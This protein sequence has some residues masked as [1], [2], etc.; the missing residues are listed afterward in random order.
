MAAAKPE[1]DAVAAAGD[2]ANVGVWS[3]RDN[4]G[5][6]FIAKVNGS[7]VVVHSTGWDDQTKDVVAED[8][9]WETAEAQRV[10]VGKSPL[11]EMTRFSGGHGSDFDGNSILVQLSPNEYIYVGVTIDSFTPVSPIQTYVSP[12]GNSCVPY[13]YAIDT[14]GRVY[15]FAGNP[16][17]LEYMTGIPANEDPN[18]YYWG[19]KP[20]NIAGSV[21]LT[22]LVPR[23]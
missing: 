23:Q 5:T 19:D 15:F 20:P 11:N 12:V 4:G 8:V 6:P 2:D 22:P 1:A 13:P 18:D 10:F 16:A 21:Q 17:A 3:I 14:E 7:K 9:V